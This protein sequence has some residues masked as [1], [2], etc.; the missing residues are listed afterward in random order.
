[1][2]LRP[3]AVTAVSFVVPKQ[4]QC[5]WLL[6][7]QN[8]FS[9]HQLPG[10]RTPVVPP[11]WPSQSTC[12]GHHES[13]SMDLSVAFTFVPFSLP[14]PSAEGFRLKTPTLGRV[15]G[16]GCDG[17]RTVHGCPWGK[18]I[19]H[20]QSRTQ[21]ALAARMRATQGSKE[22]NSYRISNSSLWW[23]CY[24]HLPNSEPQPA[25]H[26]AGVTLTQNPSW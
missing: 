15:S 22:E 16:H 23:M 9:F 7:K 26:T 11:W 18:S 2:I 19:P 21:Q 1:M 5:C 12:L 4:L 13:S 10:H 3:G 24:V 20:G 25:E 17:T 14:E 6:L 8:L